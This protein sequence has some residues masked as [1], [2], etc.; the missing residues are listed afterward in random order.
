MK[1]V[2]LDSATLGADIDLSVLAACGEL[3]AY[4]STA[5]NEVAARLADAD[6]AVIN[7]I[8]INQETLPCP[9]ALKLICVTATGF[10]NID[11]DFCRANGIAVS[12][13]VGYSTDSVAQ[14][15]LAMALSLFLHLPAYR[16]Q[17]A[18]GR[19]TEGS[20]ANSLV[21]V[22]HELAGK[23]WGVVG[24]G[25]IGKRV[26][27]LARAFGCRVIAFKRTPDPDFECC[28]LEEL[29]RRSDV[30]SVHLPL[31]EQTRAI[32][33]EKEIALMKR[34]A[35]LIN[36]ARGAVV[37]EAALARAVADRTIGGIGV[38]VY[39][40]E[41]MPKSHPF[42]AIRS[43]ENVL[44]TPHMAWGAKEARDRCIAEVVENITAFFDGKERNRV[45]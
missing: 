35:I 28:S 1:I 42:Y 21:P 8:R 32:I 37:D 31:S 20:V 6:V 13:V 29:C 16:E 14:V 19:Y 34:E 9:T 23:T 2:V 17:V 7:K 10:D 22:Y 27:E 43:F 12:N 5:P 38:D 24:L 15:T 30:I 4:P 25:H 41:P 36:V 40:C 11:L 45:D 3:V 44:L 39:S 26:A 18:D 33:G